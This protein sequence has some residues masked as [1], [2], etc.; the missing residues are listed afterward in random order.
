MNK[1]DYNMFVDDNLFAQTKLLMK[2]AMAASIE[3]LYLILGYPET[4]KRQNPLSLDKYF[5]SIW[6]Y[7][8]IQLGININT[9]SMTISL[10]EKNRIAMIK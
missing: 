3:A 2:H 9:R 5:E 8:S 4:D 1:T 7:N 6:S 10:T